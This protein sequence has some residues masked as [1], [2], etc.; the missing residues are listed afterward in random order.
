MNSTEQAQKIYDILQNA[1]D[2]VVIQ[3]DNPDG[4][5]LA[6]A[7]A[8]EDILSEQGK[9]V[10]LYCGLDIPEYLRHLSGW[11]RI[12]K[13]LPTTFD[14]SIIVDTSALSLLEQL[15][16]T[17]QR[18][19]LGTRPCI[20]LDHH[21]DVPC[22]IPFA[23]VVLNAAEAVSTG[24][25]IYEL[26]KAFK[27]QLTDLS[28]DFIAQSTL[29][30]S[31]GL[32]SEGITARSMYIMAELVEAGVSLAVLD[33]QR[34]ALMKRTPEITEYKGRLLQRIEYYAGGRLATITIPWNEIE[35]YSNAYNPSMLVLEEMRMVEGVEA[36]VAFKIY[37]DGKVTGKIRCNRGF[38]IGKD[39]ASHFGGGGHSYAAGFKITKKT[40]FASVKS[41]CIDKATHLLDELAK[42]D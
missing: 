20:V 34:R 28:R 24:E 5:S 6:S 19:W 41:A 23:T 11:D 2:I 40:D 37:N 9:T 18:A 4:D 38:G 15:D 14:A 31:L 26:C 17:N 35:Q 29:S 13:E 21:A 30:D 1:K 25:V 16:K 22:D 10:H 39:L 8:L 32:M 7:L 27:W 36:A 33:E 12:T 3:A 42:Q